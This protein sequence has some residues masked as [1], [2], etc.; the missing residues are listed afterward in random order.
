MASS[1]TRGTTRAAGVSRDEIVDRLI[2]LFRTH[3][4]EGTSIARIAAAT[5]LGKSSLYHHFPGGKEEM[6]AAV[7]ARVHDWAATHLIAPLRTD[8]PRPVRIGRMLAAV[9][10][11]YDGGRQPCLIAAMLVGTPDPGLARVLRQTVEAWL[12]AIVEALGATG[13]KRRRARKSALDA[14]ARLQGALVLARALGSPEPF[15]AAVAAMRED[16]LAA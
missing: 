5:G 6:A 12:D 13:A 15:E 3:G 7:V 11:L 14:L 9:R 2:D 16:L 1:G 8:G 10:E 4:F